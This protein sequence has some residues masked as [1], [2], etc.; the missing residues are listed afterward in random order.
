MPK[1]AFVR[2]RKHQYKTAAASTSE[3]TTGS[4]VLPDENLKRQPVGLHERDLG[5]PSVNPQI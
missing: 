2:K 4:L 1:S 3:I 5:I